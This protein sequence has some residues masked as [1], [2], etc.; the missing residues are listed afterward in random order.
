M[1]LTQIGNTKFYFGDVTKM[2]TD[3]SKEQ[4]IAAMDIHKNWWWACIDGDPTKAL[5]Y[6]TS[7]YSEWYSPQCNSDSRV[8]TSLPGIWPESAKPVQIPLS[9]VPRKFHGN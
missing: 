6:K 2:F 8:I 3:D 1:I 4:N 7:K 5:F 9:F